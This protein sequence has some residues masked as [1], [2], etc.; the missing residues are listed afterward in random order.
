MG[1]LCGLTDCEISLVMLG[2]T[3]SFK[4]RPTTLRPMLVCNLTAFRHCAPPA[5]ISPFPLRSQ[6]ASLIAKAFL[7]APHGNVTS[8]KGLG[9]LRDLLSRVFR[10]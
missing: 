8:W 10:P 4:I 7:D 1:K 3:I 2:R 9:L 6:A 5:P